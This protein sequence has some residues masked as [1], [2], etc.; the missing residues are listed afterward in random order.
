L[1]PGELLEQLEEEME[2]QEELQLLLVLPELFLPTVEQVVVVLQLMEQPVQL[3]LELQQELVLQLYL[4]EEMEQ[5]DLEPLQAKLV[6]LEEVELETMVTEAM[7]LVHFQPQL[8][9]LV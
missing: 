9:V 4:M 3:V 1:V 6:V 2:V 8:V 7:L 5:L